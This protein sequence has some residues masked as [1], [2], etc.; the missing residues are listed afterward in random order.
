VLRDLDLLEDYFAP[1]DARNLY[2]RERVDV[3]L[4]NG[5]AASAW[6]YF[7]RLD[8]AQERAEPVPSGDWRAFMAERALVDAADDWAA[9][10]RAAASD[11]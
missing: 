5:A 6:V 3:L 11:A 4:E 2:E 10:T 8:A 7:S 1:G 9:K